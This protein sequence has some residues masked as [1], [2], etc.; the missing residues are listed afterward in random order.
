MQVQWYRYYRL[1]I[2]NVILGSNL[3]MIIMPLWWG[4]AVV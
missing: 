4:Q 2:G 1:I 3:G